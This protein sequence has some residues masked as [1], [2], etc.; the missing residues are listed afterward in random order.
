MLLGRDVF[1]VLNEIK[2]YSW[3]SNNNS[4]NNGDDEEGVVDD[5]AVKD[6]GSGDSGSGTGEDGADVENGVMD[7]N[8][9]KFINCTIRTQKQFI[10]FTLL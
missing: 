2:D 1:F 9:Y 8:V 5:G 3:S 7:G 4:H 6:S 10:Y